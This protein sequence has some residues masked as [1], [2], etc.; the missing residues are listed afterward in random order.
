MNPDGVGDADDAND[1]DVA[2]ISGKGNLAEPNALVE[3]FFRHQQGRLIATLTRALG[4]AALDLAE[5]SVQEALLK[6]LR[7]WPFQGV[8]RNPGG[9][10]LVS[11]RNHALDAVRRETRWRGLEPRFLLELEAPRSDHEP[12]PHPDEIEDDVLRMIFVCCHP[13]IPRGDR[14]ALTLKTV[15]GFSTAEIA[16]AFLLPEATLA[17]RIVRAKRRIRERALAFRIPEPEE[18]PVRLSGPLDVLYLLFNAGYSSPGGEAAVRRDLMEE[19][20]RLA[21]LLC[22]HPHTQAPELHALLA[23]LLLQSSRLPA[24]LTASGALVPLADQDR[25]RWNA[26]RIDEGLLYL[27][28]AARGGV[29]SEFHLLAGIASCHAVATSLASTDW[30]RIVELYDELLRLHGS[31][32]HQ[33]NRAVAVS[34]VD[35]P[36]AAL[37]LLE[38]LERRQRLRDYYLLPA[39]RADC[40]RR[41]GRFAE[42]I[43]EYERAAALAPHD[44]ERRFLR[45]QAEWCHAS[46][47]GPR[48]HG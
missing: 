23:L 27:S 17:Q 28:L 33:L 4:P 32:V 19:A 3:H 48:P 34:M 18:L 47:R 20:I 42:S 37:A 9:W 5:E 1:A 21:R 24:R 43:S 39:A 40:L 12:S 30:P 45:A 41:L 35:G 6:A 14:V 15:S 16:R 31:F 8:P 10:L 26:G 36:L 22:G 25:A 46:C 13:E 11:A 29:A 7:V 38:P 44:P 2:A